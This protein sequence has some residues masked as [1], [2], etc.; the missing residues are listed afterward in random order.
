MSG[1]SPDNLGEKIAKAQA[2][3]AE[4]E[5]KHDAL[6]KQSGETSSA[7]AMALRFGAEFAFSILVGGFLGWWIDYFAGTKPW[8]LLIMGTFGLATGIRNV[9]RAY[10]QMNAEA[11]KYTEGLNRPDD[12]G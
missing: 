12:E 7:G 5:A 1:D 8:G 2:V 6:T 11:M 3:K 4:R 10:R 9:M